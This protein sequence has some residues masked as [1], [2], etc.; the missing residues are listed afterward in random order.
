MTTIRLLDVG[1][2]SDFDIGQATGLPVIEY[3]V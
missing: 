3:L 2:A 1:F